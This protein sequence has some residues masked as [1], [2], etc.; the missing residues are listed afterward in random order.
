MAIVEL[1]EKRDRVGILELRA[2]ARVLSGKLQVFATC[3]AIQVLLRASCS[4]AS[5]LGL[6]HLGITYKRFPSHQLD[7]MYI[8]SVLRYR[9]VREKRV[10]KETELTECVKS[11][12]TAYQF[13]IHLIL[14]SLETV[15]RP[16]APPVRS[17]VELMPSGS[18]S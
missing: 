15:K 1:D 7:T 5:L 13:G 2:P 10:E 3:A 8:V 17:R 12:L 9:W 16:K 6:Y 14:H 18:H 4:R 11:S